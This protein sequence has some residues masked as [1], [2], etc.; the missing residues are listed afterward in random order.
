MVLLVVQVFLSK[1]FV[2]VI[3]YPCSKFHFVDKVKEHF[4]TDTLYLSECN[5][6]VLVCELDF[7]LHH[8]IE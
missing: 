1:A 4:S 2:E 3:V 5:I 8:L 6:L 7:L